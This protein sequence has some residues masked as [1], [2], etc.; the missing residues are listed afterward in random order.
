MS[1]GTDSTRRRY[2]EARIVFCANCDAN[3]QLHASSHGLVC[4]ACTSTNWMYLP[5]SFQKE[6]APPQPAPDNVITALLERVATQQMERPRLRLV[7]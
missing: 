3:R 4:G 6:A 2:L 5:H 7:G 1:H